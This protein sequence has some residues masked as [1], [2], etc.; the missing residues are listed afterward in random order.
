MSSTIPIITFISDF[1]YQDEWAAICKGVIYRISPT[2]NIV[3]ICHNIPNFDIWKASFVLSSAL[4]SFPVG[5]HLAVVDP[6]VGTQRRGIVIKADRGDLLVGPDNGLLIAAAERLGGIR[7]VT[8]ITNDRFWLKPVCPTFHARDIFAPVTAYLANGIS[9][10]EIGETITEESLAKSFWEK[11]RISGRTLECQ[12][13]DV[14]KFGTLR[15]NVESS[16]LETQDL[17]LGET[18]LMKVEF[19]SD[20][21]RPH[22]L[23][24][25]PFGRTFGDVRVGSPIMLVDSSGYLCLALNQGSAA[26]HF[27][28]KRGDRLTLRL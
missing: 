23:A 7:E 12:V 16:F 19:P 20:L 2:A 6:G 26:Q 3:D 1:G 8:L 27:N 28:L 21:Q 15:F 17:S 9:P 24:E 4:P 13:I 5:V 22:I 18:I 14:D 11:P 10:A 25:V